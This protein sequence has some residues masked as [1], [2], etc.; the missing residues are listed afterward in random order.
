[1]IFSTTVVMLFALSGCVQG[2]GM[3]NYGN[4]LEDVDA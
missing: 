2:C 3:H 1:M 4:S